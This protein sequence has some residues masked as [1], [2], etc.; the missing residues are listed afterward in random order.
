M[1]S[2]GIKK[3][4]CEKCHNTEWNGQAI[5]LQIH[6]IDGNHFNNSLDNLQLLCPNC[7]AQTDNV[8]GK[9]MV[10]K[11][12]IA[13]PDKGEL[14]EKYRELKSIH[15]VSDY[16][17]ISDTTLRKWIKDLNISKEWNGIRNEIKGARKL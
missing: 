8:C 12:S 6:H 1:I 13:V 5:P 14:L 7:H 17:Q 4:E 9:N 2:Q 15:E 11:Y 3:Y 16:Y 10:G